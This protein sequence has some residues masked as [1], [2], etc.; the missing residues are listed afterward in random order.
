M[1]Q[2]QKPRILI[3]T[4]NLPP[5]VGGMERLNWH[6][7]E[8]LGKRAKVRLIG[9]AGAAAMAPPNVQVLEVPLKP[10]TRFLLMALWAAWRIARTWRPHTVLAGSGLTAPPAWLAARFCGA[11]SAVYAHGLDLAIR[12][13]LYRALWLPAIRRMDRVIANSRATERLAVDAGVDSSRIA[14]VHPGVDITTQP[15]DESADSHFR[16]E[17]GLADSPV[18]LSVGRLTRRKGLREFVTEVLPHIVA[19]RPEVVLLIVGDAPRQALS[20]EPQTRESIQSAADAEGVGKHIRFLGVITDRERLA[21]VYR[22]ADVHVFPVQQ[23]AGD[24]EGFGMVAIEAAAQGL[25]TVAYATGGV[26]DAVAP[27]QS[28]RLVPP[29]DGPAMAQAI[30][31]TLAERETL[32]NTCRAFA[33]NFSWF[34]FGAAMADALGLRDPG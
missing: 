23:I 19:A 13:P 5:L 25:P 11:S 2:L 28:G 17:L 26:V 30:E 34:R 8:E 24:P 21:T 1:T 15:P 32:R 14:I 16:A 9:P 31:E 12:H 33:E 22:A 4:R 29:G 7:A 20:A 3:I 6:M 27:G 10:L 18:L